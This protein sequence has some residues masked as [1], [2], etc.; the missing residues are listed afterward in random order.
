M[1]LFGKPL[2]ERKKKCFIT[3]GT[4]KLSL[5]ERH[6][7][8]FSVELCLRKNDLKKVSFLLEKN[9]HPRFTTLNLPL[10]WFLRDDVINKLIKTEILCA[11]S[12]NHIDTDDVI[13]INK[14]III[15][16]LTKETY[17]K[18][19]LM[20]KPSSFS[21]IPS[22]WNVTL[23]M[24]DSAMKRG[25]KGFNRILW[26]FENNFQREF[27]FRMTASNEDDI[28]IIE[29]VIGLSS[30]FVK[31]QKHESGKIRCPSFS[32]PEKV[33]DL[34][35]NKIIKTEWAMEIYEWLGLVSL[36]ADRL[37]INDDCDPYI[38]TYNLSNASEDEVI[39]FLWSGMISSGWIL[40]LW[41]SLQNISDIPWLSL[42]VNG[43]EDSPISWENCEHGYFYGGENTYTFLKLN[44]NNTAYISHDSSTFSDYIIY[45]YVCS[46]DRHS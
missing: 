2:K 41:L 11:L 26:S 40:N 43:F 17:E 24:R 27:S 14:G 32:Y 28:K 21:K 33:D 9:T 31:F 3:Y 23:D 19:G 7:F 36:G 25:K 18:A 29:E 1:E 5:I 39:T 4:P 35:L 45:E 15:L 37:N 13:C 42:T 34:N 8:N 16:S 12:M 10:N 44:S 46:Y 30:D 22:R 6:P 38:S 20:G